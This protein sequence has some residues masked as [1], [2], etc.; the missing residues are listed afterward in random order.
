M[1]NRRTAIKQF[2]FISAGVAIIPSCIND[3]GKASIPLKNISLSGSQESLLAEIG[4]TLIPKTDQPGAKDV[5]AHLFAMKMIDD[6]STKEDQQKFIS[7]IGAFENFAKQKNGKPFAE[8]DATQK[9]A[10]IA[11]LDKVN[12]S[13]DDIAFF[14]SKMKQLT[15]QAYTSSQFYM[16]KVHEYKMLPGK[17]EGCVPVKNA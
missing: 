11:A 14:Y 5:G 2:I 1:P 9:D 4:E 8:S 12:D 3:E 6:C 13:K 10:V 16:T 17:F 15:I 7:G